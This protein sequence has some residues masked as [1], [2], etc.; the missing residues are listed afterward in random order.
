M[1]KIKLLI[2]KEHLSIN[3]KKSLYNSTEK[4]KQTK[5]LGTW[6]EYSQKKKYIYTG[7]M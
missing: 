7:P 1:T 4:I 3:M 2:Y 6:T 5:K